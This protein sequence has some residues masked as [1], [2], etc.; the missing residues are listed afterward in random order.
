M[1]ITRLNHNQPR[2]WIKV[3]LLIMACFLAASIAMPAMASTDEGGHGESA[4]AKGW[5]AT[6]TYRVMNFAVLAIALF[7]ILKKP[8]ANAL[9]GRIEG[10]R[11][12]LGDLEAKKEAAQ[13][14][15]TQYNQKLAALDKEAEQIMADY[16]R[17][18]EEAKARILEEAKQ[19]AVKLEDQA[20]RNIDAEFKQTKEKIHAEILEKAMAKAEAIVQEKITGDDQERLVDDYLEKVVAS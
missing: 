1:R 15:L 7:F 20:K 8:F 16:L 9:N 18:G 19:A 17:Q 10:I 6:D 14:E 3:A 4:G 12:E 11:S 13:K 2:K 5:V